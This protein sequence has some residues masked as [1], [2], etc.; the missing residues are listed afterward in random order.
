MWREDLMPTKIFLHW[1]L[2]QLSTLFPS[3]LLPNSQKEKHREILVNFSW[4]SSSLTHFFNPP[5]WLALTPPCWKSLTKTTMNTKLPHNWSTLNLHVIWSFY[6]LWQ[7]NH[8]LLKATNFFA[9][10]SLDSCQVS[11]QLCWLPLPYFLNVDINQSRFCHQ[12]S[13]LFLL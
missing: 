2:L 12:S 13:Y 1:L 10:R 4:L 6:F 9:S 3:L 8:I 5:I 7:F 11:Y